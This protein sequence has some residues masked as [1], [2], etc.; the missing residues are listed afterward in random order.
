MPNP[1]TI[2]IQYDITFYQFTTGILD[3][4]FTFT[5][6]L[7]VG[8]PIICPTAES[9]FW[10]SIYANSISTT[11]EVGSIALFD[12]SPSQTGGWGWSYYC[13]EP[14]SLAS[15]SAY[16]NFTNCTAP[17]DR[18]KAIGPAGSGPERVYIGGPYTDNNL[19]AFI[20]PPC[21]GRL[22][23]VSAD[24]YRVNVIQGKDLWHFL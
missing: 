19:I 14:G 10:I 2:S 4:E 21:Y 24:V 17:Y 16:I 3:P 6:F 18:Y 20:W 13:L 11:T 8:D 7:P 15:S 5:N 9:R 22:N 1:V 23:L 12:E